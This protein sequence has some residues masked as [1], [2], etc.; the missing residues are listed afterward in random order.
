MTRRF[1]LT[2]LLLVVSVLAL[3]AI[4]RDSRY[5]NDATGTDTSASSTATRTMDATQTAS[6]GT[7]LAAALSVEA[8]ATSPEAIAMSDFDA[9]VR[10]LHDEAWWLTENARLEAAEEHA[11]VTGR[12]TGSGPAPG[13][14][15]NEPAPASNPDCANPIIS[16]ATAMRES[17]C[18]WDAYNPGGCGGRSCLGFFQL[19]AGHFYAVSPWNPNV[20]GSC[21][22]LD[23]NTRE[24]QTECASRLGP[25][26]WG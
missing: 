16:E 9:T 17:G 3:P 6:L 4:P 1:P 25:G 23:P 18:Q 12:P 14:G 2:S 7:R 15:R 22:G 21:Y 13:T 24:G 26:A 8:T 11:G 10:V 5:A 19:D 20:S